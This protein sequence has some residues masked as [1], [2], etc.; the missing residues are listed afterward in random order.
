MKCI[1]CIV[2]SGMCNRLLPFITSYRL[3][4]I[5]NYEYYLVWDDNNRYEGR[6]T[7]YCDLFK[8]I[9]E[10]NYITFSQY[11]H[12]KSQYTDN[13]INIINYCDKNTISNLNLDTC[14]TNFDMIVFN[15]YVHPIS[16][17]EDSTFIKSYSLNNSNLL[18]DENNYY[19]KSVSNIFKELQPS[20]IILDKINEVLEKFPIN[21]NVVAFHVRHWPQNWIDNFSNL[22]NDNTYEKRINIMNKLITDN[23]EIKFYISTT[24]E[25]ALKKLINLFDKRIIYFKNRFGNKEDHFYS[26][27]FKTDCCNLNKNLNGVV[28]MYVMSK[29]KSIYA[30]K[31]SSFSLTSKMMNSESKIYYLN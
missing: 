31:A 19:L 7:T 28:D 24:N 30:E 13:K 15:K 5:L 23:P 14:M 26:S 27:D 25:K 12:I 18:N 8:K 29:C 22:I 11:E 4:K 2:Q 20:T 16:L 3:S 1:V 9:N 6:K 10:V 21:N 17:K